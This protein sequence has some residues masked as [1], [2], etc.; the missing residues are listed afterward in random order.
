MNASRLIS[1][2]AARAARRPLPF[3]LAAVLLALAGGALALRLH[4]TAATDTFVS[5][6]S[7]E[8]RATQTFYRGF[9][10]EPV[11]VLVRGSLQ[12]LVLST[13]IDRLV[14][15]EGCLSGNVPASAFAHEGGAH[16]PCAGLA[17][18]HTVR[19]VL[20][21]GTFV[22]EAAGR[23]DEQIAAQSS[24]AQAQAKQAEHVFYEQAL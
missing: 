9:G 13:D 14:G 18:A 23:I 7:P 15:L 19:V 22:N 6:S 5:S 21:P 8:Y 2:L 4:P 3:L 17:R 12:Q 24:Q 1:G 10:E 11:E 20:G 16:G